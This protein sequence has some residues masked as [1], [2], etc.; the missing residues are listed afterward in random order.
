[1]EFLNTE[2]IKLRRFSQEDYTKLLRL[3][4]NLEVMKYIGNGIPATRERV[5]E[6]LNLIISK[7]DEWVSYG[8]WAAEFKTNSNFIGWFAL[9]PLPKMGE[10]EVGYRLLPEYW[11]QGFATEG[12]RALIEYGFEKCGLEKIVAITHLENRA[13]QKVLLKCGL[14]EKGFIPDPFSKD[15]N[16]QQVRYFEISK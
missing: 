11:G 1:M 12:A 6:V 7:Y 8:L 3:D 9:K 10:I 13:S 16:Q 2:R 4:S 14:I 15:E 5:Q